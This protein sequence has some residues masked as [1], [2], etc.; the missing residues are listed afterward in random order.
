MDDPPDVDCAYDLRE[1][2]ETK[3]DHDEVTIEIERAKN[4][5]FNF[6]LS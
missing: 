4:G 5:C 6:K 3:G 2:R 1:V